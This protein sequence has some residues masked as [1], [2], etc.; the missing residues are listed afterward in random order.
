MIVIGL[1]AR[2]QP[3]V[4]VGSHFLDRIDSNVGR[5]YGIERPVKP[6]KF[7]GPIRVEVHYLSVGVNSS[8]GSPRAMGGHSMVQDEPNRSIQFS[9]DGWCVRLELPSPIR[10]AIVGYC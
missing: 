7:Q 6:P 3:G 8:V 2:G 9:L 4:E 1:G 10:G 5:K